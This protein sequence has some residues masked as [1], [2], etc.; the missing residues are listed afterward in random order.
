V[1]RAHGIRGFVQV[2]PHNASSDALD[3][4]KRVELLLP[5][6][7]RRSVD[8][9][10]CARSGR[11]YLVKFAGVDDRE[12]AQA[13]T[14]SAVLVPRSELPPL[15]EGE[16]YLVDLV[17]AEVVAPDGVIGEVV[18]V[19]VHPS[20]DTLVIRRADG[21]LVELALLPAFVAR[22]DPAAR[23]VELHNRDGLIE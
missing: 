6:G 1:G 4:C 20:V 8:V 11:G 10:S 18:E 21:K 22:L 13:L 17:G 15:G 7:E 9:V 14:H 19:A 5:S 23:R 3:E 12:A 2:R 16:A